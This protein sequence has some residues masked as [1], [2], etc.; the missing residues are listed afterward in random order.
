M[1]SPRAYAD[2]IKRFP[3]LMK[4]ILRN[5]SMTATTGVLVN[6]FGLNV[7]QEKNMMAIIRDVIAQEYLPRDI[8]V[9]VRQELKLDEQRTK[10]L[11]LEILGRIVLP[12]S[13]YIGN[14][15]QPIR[16]LGGDPAAYQEAVIEL[17]PELAAQ[18]PAVVP[19]ATKAKQALSPISGEAAILRDFEDRLTTFRGRAEILLRLTG[20]SA[21]IDEAM[22]TDKISTDDGQQLLQQLD[23]I[24]AAINTQDL[25]SFEIQSLKRRVERVLGKTL[26]L[27]L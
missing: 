12:I 7:A 18:A 23:S 27:G 6:V 16:D 20:L 22:H 8:I 3:P 25:N 19:T 21:Q 14:V 24:S 1:I 15:D 9:H 17:Y 4:T 13:W 2:V 11:A 26:E 10:A 5:G